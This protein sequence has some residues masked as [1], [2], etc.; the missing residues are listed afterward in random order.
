MYHHDH[1]SDSKT[2]RGFFKTEKDQTWFIY[3]KYRKDYAV[4]MMN[5]FDKKMAEEGGQGIYTD[6][7]NLVQNVLKL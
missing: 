2:L 5:K 1:L 6:A 4:A 3:Q 7:F